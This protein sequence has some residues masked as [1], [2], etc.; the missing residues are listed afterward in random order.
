MYVIFDIFFV[1]NRFIFV[2]LII[3]RPTVIEKSRKIYSG[4]NQ[5]RTINCTVIRANPSYLRY[6][7]N[8]LSP[9]V[10]HR[11]YGDQHSLVYSFDIAPSSV[12]H[13][14]FFNVTA[15]NS[16][17]FDVCTYELI[18]GGNFKSFWS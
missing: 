15:N 9:S 2:C 7:V 4:I 6:T 14:G 5:T 18:H 13:F 17:G 12:E 1:I 10:I 11:T 8:G 16:A 3:V